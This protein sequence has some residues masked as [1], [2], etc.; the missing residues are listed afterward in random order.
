MLRNAI[1]GAVLLLTGFL[2]G[3]L[4]WVYTSAQ[5]MIHDGHFDLTVNVIDHGSRFRAVHCEAYGTRDVAEI[6]AQQLQ[7][8]DPAYFATADPFAGEPLTV[9]VPCSG[10]ESMSGRELRRMQ[11]GYLAVIGELPDGRKVGSVV[12]IPDGRV[13]QEVNVTLP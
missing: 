9:R 5:Y 12:E 10:R 6:V 3:G 13:S 8:S 1:I 7:P 4:A 11:F 2:S